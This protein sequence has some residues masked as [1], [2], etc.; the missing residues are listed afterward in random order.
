VIV[1]KATVLQ[2]FNGHPARQRT[3]TIVSQQPVPSAEIEV[4][5]S[6]EEKEECWLAAGSYSSCSSVRTTTNPATTAINLLASTPQPTHQQ[7]HNGLGTMMMI[8]NLVS[9]LENLLVIEKREV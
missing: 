6:H 2:V 7:M 8:P 9:M 1:I 3:A 5:R 4:D